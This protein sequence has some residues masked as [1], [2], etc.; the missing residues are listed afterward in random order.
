M[1]PN[2]SSNRLSYRYPLSEKVEGLHYFL[3]R[4]LLFARP[5]SHDEPRVM[6][7]VK[8]SRILLDVFT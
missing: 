7:D 4:G 3:V 5:Y 2:H 1:N 8:V 6:F